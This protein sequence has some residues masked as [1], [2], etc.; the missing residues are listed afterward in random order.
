MQ[1]LSS[2]FAG[3]MPWILLGVGAL[4]IIAVV[5]AML[6]SRRQSDVNVNVS[7]A[8]TLSAAATPTQAVVSVPVTVVVTAVPAT[9]A[10]TLI[11]TLPPPPPPTNVPVVV[12]TAPPPVTV[13]A[14]TQVVPAAPPPPPPPAPTAASAKPTVA[15]P[16]PATPAAAAK[17]TQPSADTFTGQVSGPGGA[18]N[19]RADVDAAYGPPAGETPSR[20]VVYRR[21]PVEIQVLFSADPARVL[22]EARVTPR[23]G[24]ISLESAQS[25]AKAMLPRD[26]ERRGGAAEGNDTFVV[27]RWKSATLAKALPESAFREM[28]GA[29]G[30]LLTLYVKTPAGTVERTIAGIGDSPEQLRARMGP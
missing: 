28:G 7:A 26:V 3:R 20:L 23:D 5:G 14:I 30:D 12:P 8:A 29:A 2:R 13:V 21:P 11:P 24:A 4:A 10:P 15:V 16:P 6:A 22:A 25:A 17:P 9:V 18:G 19:T 1:D 27:E